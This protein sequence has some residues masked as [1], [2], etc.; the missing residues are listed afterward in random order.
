MRVLVNDSSHVCSSKGLFCGKASS[1]DAMRCSCVPCCTQLVVV[2]LLV[3][4]M[5]LLL[6]LLVGRWPGV[7]IDTPAARSVSSTSHPP[8]GLGLPCC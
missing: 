4:H 7:D 8:A 2:L 5:L 1:G 3:L 6:L